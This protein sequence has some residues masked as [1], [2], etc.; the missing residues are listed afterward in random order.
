MYRGAARWLEM[1]QLPEQ[2]HQG[3]D[4][5]RRAQPPEDREGS[6]P[7]RTGASVVSLQLKHRAEIPFDVGEDV[8]RAVLDAGRA[9]AFEQL[10]GGRHVAPCLGDTCL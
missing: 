6:F 10:D 5:L 7:G 3:V 8:R 9:G 4:L 2:R 1:K